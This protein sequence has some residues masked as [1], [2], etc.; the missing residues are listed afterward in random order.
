MKSGL[1]DLLLGNQRR[2]QPSGPQPNEPRATNSYQPVPWVIPVSFLWTSSHMS[3]NSSC[4]A[5]SSYWVV[6]YQPANSILTYS[7]SLKEG[8]SPLMMSSVHAMTNSIGLRYM[9][10]N[11]TLD[12]VN[13][14]PL[15]FLLLIWLVSN[16]ESV[17]HLHIFSVSCRFK[18]EDQRV[19][20]C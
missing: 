8:C 7:S 17:R 5:S 4:C 1:C 9:K 14:L 3:H 11:L 18:V 10:R 12:R 15:D 16:S 2:K 19:V 20:I 6:N 13:N